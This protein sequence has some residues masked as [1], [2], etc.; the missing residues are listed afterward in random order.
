M[1]YTRR[2]ADGIPEEQMLDQPAPGMN[3]PAWILGHLAIAYD[4]ALVQA[5]KAYTLPRDWLKTYG[6]GSS[7]ALSEA[8]HSKAELLSTLERLHA[9]VLQ[10]VKETT[11]E[12]LAQPHDFEPMKK[13]MAARGD[14]LLHLLTTHP[15]SH[16]GQLSAWRRFK[17]LPAVLGF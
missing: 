13:V 4:F 11:D 10:A 15:V 3:T 7:P 9:D 5:G 8:R 6:P 12:H 14:L 17:G 1:E 16:L 2:L